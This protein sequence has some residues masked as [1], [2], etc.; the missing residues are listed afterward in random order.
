MSEVTDEVVLEPLRGPNELRDCR[1]VEW[2]AEGQSRV[3]E[4]DGVRVTIRFIS[5]RGRRARIAIQAPSGSVFR[6]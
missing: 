4:I 5:R 6:S 3:V 2:Y 1:S